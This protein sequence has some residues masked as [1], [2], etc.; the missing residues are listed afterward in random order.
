MIE[1]PLSRSR[2]LAELRKLLNQPD[3]EI[4]ERRL[5]TCG[6]SKWFTTSPHRIRIYLDPRRDGRLTV[7][8]HELVHIYFFNE[9]KMQ[10]RFAPWLEEAIV[11]GLEIELTRYVKRS[12]RRLNSWDR[13]IA[14]KMIG[15][16][17]AT[18]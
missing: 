12:T 6:H 16:R 9:M 18:R 7:V 8:L 13:A 2:L 1:R 17:R 11:V 5:R 15:G 4:H 14:R 10:R 3:T